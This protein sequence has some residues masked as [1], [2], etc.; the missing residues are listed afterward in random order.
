[1]RLEKV[2]FFIYILCMDKLE[3][4]QSLSSLFQENGYILYLVGGAVRDYLIKGEIDDLDCVSDATPDDIST[5][6]KGEANYRFKAYGSVTIKYLGFKFDVTTLRKEE[7]YLDSRHPTKVTFVRE[8]DV[9]VIRRDFTING[10]YMD[11]S[12]HVYDYVNGIN[13]LNKKMLK[14]IGIS[15]LRIKEDP[16]RILRAIRFSLTFDFVMDNELVLAIKENINLLTLLNPEK[17][18]QELKKIKVPFDKAKEKFDYFN[19]T[20]LLDMLK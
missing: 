1:M 14:M 13:D 8:L 18:K 12:L 4:Y 17:V 3:A 19:I 2:S 11:S 15:D 20:Y 7:S 16:L 10:L 6:F 5:F 9:D